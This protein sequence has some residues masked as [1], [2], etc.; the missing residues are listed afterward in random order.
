MTCIVKIGQDG[1]TETDIRNAMKQWNEFNE[2]ISRPAFLVSDADFDGIVKYMRISW[3]GFPED[4]VIEKT[5]RKVWLR[6][7]EIDCNIY[8]Y[9]LQRNSG[10]LCPPK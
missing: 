1:F 3:A 5:D 9:C 10:V 6:R 8:Q 4:M 2:S 7:D